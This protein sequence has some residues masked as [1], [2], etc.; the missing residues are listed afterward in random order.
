M[1]AMTAIQPTETDIF[2][3]IEFN[4]AKG[5]YEI[6]FANVPLVTDVPAQDTPEAIQKLVED[7]FPGANVMFHKPFDPA[8]G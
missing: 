5:Q 2:L 4:Q 7:Q 3:M 6:K 1:G 8:L